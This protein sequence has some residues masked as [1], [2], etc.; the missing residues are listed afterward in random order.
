MMI[1]D[2]LMSMMIVDVVDVID[3]VILKKK[4]LCVLIFVF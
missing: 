3:I 4:A 2:I 1:K